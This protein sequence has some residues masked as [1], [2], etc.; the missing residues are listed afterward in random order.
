MHKNFQKST[1]GVAV[2]T[3]LLLLLPI[4]L[5]GFFMVFAF[6]AGLA[7]YMLAAQNPRCALIAMLAAFAVAAVFC[8]QQ[9]LWFLAA[10]LLCGFWLGRCCLRHMRPVPTFLSTLAVTL[11]AAMA[12]RSVFSCPLFGISCLSIWTYLYSAFFVCLGITLLYFLLCGWLQRK[13]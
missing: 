7:I 13:L 10:F 11:A 5:G 2:I 4:L 1:V 12:I 3:A 8:F 9:A 6:F